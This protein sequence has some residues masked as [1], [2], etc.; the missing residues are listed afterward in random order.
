MLKI[1]GLRRSKE[2][3][4]EKEQLVSPRG[5][6][7]PRGTTTNTASPRGRSTTPRG[8]GLVKWELKLVAEGGSPVPDDAPSATTHITPQASPR[9]LVS[10]RWVDDKAQPR[11]QKHRTDAQ[12][13]AMAALYATNPAAFD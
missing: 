2:P 3:A 11:I 13:G 10:P 12:L 7:T 8:E 5:S 9:T 4:D 6:T 1:P